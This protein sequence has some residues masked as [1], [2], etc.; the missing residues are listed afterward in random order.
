MLD[1][2][3]KLIMKTVWE[4]SSKKSILQFKVRYLQIGNIVGH[5]TRFKG[6]VISSSDLNEPE[7]TLFI[8]ANSIE[9]L[10]AELNKKLRTERFLSTDQYPLIKFISP[11]GCKKSSGG[12][13][14]L[15]GDLFIKESKV[16]VT[17]PISYS[18]VNL[19]VEKS[20]MIFHLFGQ[21]ATNETVITFDRNSGIG[22]E[23]KLKAE[24]IL[25]PK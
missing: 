10:N 9:T 14:E 18:S 7:V 22:D 17:M 6:Q 19:K 16:Q 12:I 25:L 20:P 13:W 21:I 2:Y 8:E 4:I 11:N 23:M 1:C 5:F 3:L 15:T 24:I